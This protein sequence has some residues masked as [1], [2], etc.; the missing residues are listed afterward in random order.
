MDS[1]NNQRDTFIQTDILVMISKYI[2][3]VD[4]LSN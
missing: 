4:E 2:N 3:K 1:N